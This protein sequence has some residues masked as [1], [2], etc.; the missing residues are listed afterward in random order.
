MIVNPVNSVVPAMAEMYKKKGLDPMKIVGI[1]TLDVVRANKFVG[2]ITNKNPNY[3]NV[4]V[5][6]GHSRP[7]CRHRCCECQ[8]WQGQRHSVDGIC[9]C[10]VRESCSRWVEREEA[11]RVCVLQVRRHG[12][13]VLLHTEGGFR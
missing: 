2:E 5:I 11:H 9:R 10:K 3:I 8:G 7:E 4:P 13:F 1:T 6:G 12:G